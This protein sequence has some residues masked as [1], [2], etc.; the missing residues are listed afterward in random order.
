MPPSVRDDHPTLPFSFSC[1]HPAPAQADRKRKGNREHK[2]VQEAPEDVEEAGV[3]RLYTVSMMAD[4]LGVPKAAVRHWVRSEL[5]LATKKAGA[6]EWFDFQQLVIGRTLA[7]L[8]MR[9]FSLREIDAKLTTLVPTSQSKVVPCTSMILIDGRRLSI[10]KRGMILGAGGQLQFR[11]YTDALHDVDSAHDQ[12]ER[13]FE[14]TMIN[15][16]ECS[17]NSVELPIGAELLDLAADLES[18]GKF[19]EAAE[20]IRAFLQSEHPSPQVMF[21]LAELL[22]RSGD[23]TAARERYYATLEMDADHLE[24]RTSL[25]CV[26]AELGD[27]E[28]AIAALEGVLRQEPEYADA[29]WHIASVLHECGQLSTCRQHLRIFLALAPESPWASLA[30]ERLQ[31]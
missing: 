27:H 17:D 11:F 15:D 9:G 14:T 18:N 29:H 22:Y 10:K 26:L 7:R 1:A 28:L 4:V 12:I 5:L 2:I 24:A 6:L 25:A 8:L 21:M 3:R 16:R 19:V 23:L 30:R 13:H 31:Q 20:A